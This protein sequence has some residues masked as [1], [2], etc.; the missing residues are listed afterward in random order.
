MGGLLSSCKCSVYNFTMTG[1]DTFDDHFT[2]NSDVTK[3]GSDYDVTLKGKI[4]D[5]KT[6]AKMEES[7]IVSWAPSAP[8]WV[9]EVGEHYEYAVVYACVGALGQ[10]LEYV[11]IFSRDPKHVPDVAGITTRLQAQ[12]IDASAIKHVPQDGCTYPSLDSPISEEVVDGEAHVCRF[13]LL[14]MGLAVM[15]TLTVIAITAWRGH[16]NATS[17]ELLEGEYKRAATSRDQV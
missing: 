2:C 10:S 9:L 8:Y 13:M 11:Y 4:P 3:P 16:H 14:L 1:S 12:G 5:L 6:P 7:P 17:M 15:T